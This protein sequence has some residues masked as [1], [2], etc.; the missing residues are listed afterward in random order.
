MDCLLMRHG[1]AVE[2]EKWEG[3]E[4]HR[5]LTTKGKK[6]TSQAAAGLAMLGLT[7]TRLFSSPFVRAYETARL[8]RDVACPALRIEKRKELAVG[9]SPEQVLPFLHSIQTDTLVI[10][11]GHEP[12]LGEVASL[13][14]C[15]QSI[16]GF[17]FKKAGAA[18]I[19]LPDG[20][21]PGQ[22]ILRW[23]LQPMQLRILGK[24]M[25]VKMPRATVDQSESTMHG[26]WSPTA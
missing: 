17:S 3:S 22:G 5:P 13:L 19:H 9:A 16:P 21:K 6:R 14:L 25:P 4:E 23:W 15:G 11:V 10:C 18:L 8:L 24:H 26:P 1:I 7:P 2:S 20:P 12:L